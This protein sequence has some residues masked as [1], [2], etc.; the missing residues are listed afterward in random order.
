MQDQTVV[1]TGAN[2]GLGH[3]LV[4]TFVDEGAQVYG[5]VRDQAH[6]EPL[7]QELGETRF[8]ALTADVADPHAVTDV[9]NQIVTASGGIDVLFNNAAVY[10]RINF[11]EQS[12]EDWLQGLMINLG[13]VANCCKAVLPHMISAG[14]GKI[15]NVGSWADLHPIA[16]SSLYSTTKGGLHA[17]TK[18]IAV[19]IADLNLPIEVHEWLPGVLNTRMS[20]FAGIDPMLSA[21]WAVQIVRSEASSRNVIFERDREWSPPRGLRQKLKERLLF[22]R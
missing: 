5:V 1:V 19:D 20:E 7:Q 12:S 18:S 22:W 13:G 2:R 21:S 8:Q 14:H 17:L 15:Y 11:L 10:P 4:K 3:A 16:D 6:V 9:V